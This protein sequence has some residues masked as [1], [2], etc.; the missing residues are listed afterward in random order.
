M[1]EIF[2]Y[3]FKK[4]A[5]VTRNDFEGGTTIKFTKLKVALVCCDF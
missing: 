1:L 4:A 2:Q 5:L 3:L